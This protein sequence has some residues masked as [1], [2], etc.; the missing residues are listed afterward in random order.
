MK[1]YGAD[2]VVSYK[3]SDDAIIDEIVSNTG[4]NL[5]KVYDATSQLLHMAAP[6]F[7]KTKDGD[8]YFTSTNDW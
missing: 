3:Q 6:L 2:E 5:F 1:H 8:K 7:K 4:G